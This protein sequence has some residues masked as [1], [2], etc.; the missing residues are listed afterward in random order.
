MYK[1]VFIL[2]Q[3][4][5]FILQYLYVLVVSLLAASMIIYI[6][7]YCISVAKDILFRK[8]FPEMALLSIS[9]ALI[10][11]GIGWLIRSVFG[12]EI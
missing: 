10:G 9:V 2:I 4:C 6:F 8:R 12:T 1:Y 11:F 7:N 3:P 5:I